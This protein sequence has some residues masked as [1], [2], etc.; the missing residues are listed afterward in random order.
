MVGCKVTK[1]LE[2]KEFLLIKN[3]IHTT[4]LKIPSEDFEP[5]IQQIPNT[6]FLGLFRTNIAIY[7]MGNKGKDSKFKKWLRLKVG[8]QPVILDTSMVTVSLKQMNIYLGNKGY[9]HSLSSDTI[10]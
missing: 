8:T 7:N 1:T 10:L 3:K 4:G 5:Y 6:K 9:F 2:S